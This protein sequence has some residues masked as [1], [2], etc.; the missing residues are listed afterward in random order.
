MIE[1]NRKLCDAKYSSSILSYLK[2]LI[3]NFESLPD[4][5]ILNSRDMDELREAVDSLV[6]IQKKSFL[7]YSLNYNLAVLGSII[8][9]AFHI[10]L[11]DYVDDS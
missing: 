6:P 7:L 3:N 8:Y 5:S 11:K 1:F 9:Q 4:R 2:I 10:Q